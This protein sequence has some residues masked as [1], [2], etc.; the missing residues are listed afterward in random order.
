MTELDTTYATLYV[1]VR[2]ETAIESEEHAT[3]PQTVL[4]LGN[5][6]CALTVFLGVRDLGRLVDVVSAALTA[7]TEREVSARST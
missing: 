7:L 2:A 4:H 6:P 3:R 1:H 5:S